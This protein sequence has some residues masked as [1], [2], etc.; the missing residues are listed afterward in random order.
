[1]CRVSVGL[2][3]YGQK[4]SSAFPDEGG[5]LATG[6]GRGVMRVVGGGGSYRSWSCRKGVEKAEGGGAYCTTVGPG[7][8][9]AA[10]PAISSINPM[11]PMIGPMNRS[12]N[13]FDPL[14][15]DVTG[16]SKKSIAPRI[17]RTTPAATTPPRTS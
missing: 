13:G 5:S 15:L 4:P 10:S 7:V 16:Y 3:Q 9:L 1:M 2:P 6:G 12:P 11:N 14:L 17:I 8:G